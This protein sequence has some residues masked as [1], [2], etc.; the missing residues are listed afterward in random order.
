LAI[1]SGLR[2]IKVGTLDEA[3]HALQGVA[4]GRSDQPGC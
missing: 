3:V 2:L 1:P 4:A